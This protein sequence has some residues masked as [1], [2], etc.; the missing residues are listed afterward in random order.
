MAPPLL[1]GQIKSLAKTYE[2][3]KSLIRPVSADQPE[4][5]P[6]VLF[7]TQTYAQA[8]S[9]YLQFYQNTAASVSDPTLSNFA[10]GTLDQRQY[11]EIHR[12]FTI[13]HTLPN[14][15]L[16]AVI[17]GAASDIEIL[18]KTARGIV[19][20]TMSTKPYGG[21]PLAFFGRPGGPLPGYAAFGT[22][23]VAN[24][25]ITSGETECNGGF[26]IMG[27]QIIP[28]QTPFKCTMQF[29]STAISAATFITHAMMGVLHRTVG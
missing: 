1:L 8:G 27:N 18:H 12:M 14:L 4:S 22:G 3:L 11:F 17:T 21:I 28:P 19:S 9:Q 10:S 25:I 5:I 15:N 13:V 23:T 24:D 26:P 16:T 2:N 29:V 20:W 7:D 6:H